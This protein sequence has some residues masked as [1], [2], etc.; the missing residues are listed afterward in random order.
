MKRKSFCLTSTQFSFSSSQDARRVDNADILKDFI[1]HLNALKPAKKK[2]TFKIIFYFSLFFFSMNKYWNGFIPQCLFCANEGRT[3]ANSKR[4]LKETKQMKRRNTSETIHYFP[5]PSTS[6]HLFRNAF[7]KGSRLRKG[8]FGSTVRALPG[9]IPSTFPYMR[10]VKQSVVGSGPTL[11]PGKSS[12]MRYLKP[13]PNQHHYISAID[14]AGYICLK[15]HIAWKS[16]I[17]PDKSCL[18]C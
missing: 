16:E 4:N 14:S 5:S 17:L 15:M 13:S 2:K 1:W 12:S 18:S 11:L 8:F 7:P 10:A 3:F 9:M 6:H